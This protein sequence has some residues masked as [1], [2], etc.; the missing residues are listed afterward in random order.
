M[1]GLLEFIRSTYVFLIFVILEVAALNHYA[2]SSVY[3]RARVLARAAYV[4]GRVNGGIN[5]VK[6]YFSLGRENNQLLERLAELE[7]RLAAY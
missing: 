2:H 7:N 4:A 3:A 1:R 6:R 5:E